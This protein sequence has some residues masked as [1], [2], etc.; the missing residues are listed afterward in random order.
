MTNYEDNGF[1]PPAPVARIHV[2]CPKTGKTAEN[3][4]M[5]LDTGA[6]VTLLPR[7]ALF[8]L[9]DS[10][11]E[12]SSFELEGFDGTRTSAKA[13]NLEVRFL[14]KL[15][16]G[17]FLIVDGPYGFMGRN[18]LNRLSLTFDGPRLTWRENR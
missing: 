11:V 12:S 16:R 9:N 10:V 3:V 1:R 5:L 13:I 18:L 7:D 6:D 2:R 14:G 4:P 17:E 15:F 8:D